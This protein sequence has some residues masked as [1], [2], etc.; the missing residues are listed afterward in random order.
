[1]KLYPILHK[2]MRSVGDSTR[3]L[4]IV[5]APNISS[6]FLSKWQ[7]AQE[8]RPKT[9]QVAKASSSYKPV[10]LLVRSIWF[11]WFSW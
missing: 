11:L 3:L 8:S 6:G 4:W 5:G 10:N 1:V 9:S 2:D 7:D